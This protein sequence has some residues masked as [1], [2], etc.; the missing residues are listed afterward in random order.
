MRIGQLFWY[1]PERAASSWHKLTSAVDSSAAQTHQ[2]L[3]DKSGKESRGET[4]QASSPAIKP[5]KSTAESLA[6]EAPKP[7]SRPAPKRDEEYL[8]RVRD[9]LAE[10]RE[11]LDQLGS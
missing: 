1:L 4:A 10:N 6:A 3:R 5:G 8:Q 7:K 9:L 2:R 11:L